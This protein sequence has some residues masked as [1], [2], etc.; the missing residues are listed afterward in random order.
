MT[1]TDERMETLENCY[2]A[3][4]SK[5]GDVV[6]FKLKSLK[7]SGVCRA[8]LVNNIGDYPAMLMSEVFIGMVGDGDVKWSAIEHRIVPWDDVEWLVPSDES[9][10]KLAGGSGSRGG[11]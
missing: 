5:R 6:E 4:Y 3:L 1:N 7:D 10:L 8:R 11:T 2:K 9:A